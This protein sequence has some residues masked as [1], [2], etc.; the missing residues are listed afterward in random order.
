MGSI[1][2]VADESTPT[3]R[4]ADHH[5]ATAILGRGGESA[6]KSFRAAEERLN[7]FTGPELGLRRDIAVIS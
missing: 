7:L 5:G 2:A 3:C 4:R 1:V 6:Q